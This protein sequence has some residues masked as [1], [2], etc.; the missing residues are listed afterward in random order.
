MSARN[1]T[2]D[3]EIEDRLAG[4]DFTPLIVHPNNEGINILEEEGGKLA[5]SIET[6]LW[7][8]G[9]G[10]LAMVLNDDDYAPLYGG[11]IDEEDQEEDGDYT[12]HL[13]EYDGSALDDLDMYASNVDIERAKEQH[14]VKKRETAVAL[15]VDAALK[16]KL[17]DA[18]SKEYLEKLDA[19]FVGFK[20]VTFKEMIEHLRS[21]YCKLYTNDTNELR[22]R[23]QEEYDATQHVSTYFRRLD[24]F[25]RKLAK[26]HLIIHESQKV[27]QAVKQMYNGG[28]FSKEQL[29]DWESLDREDKSWANL[30]EYFTA[31]YE[32]HLNFKN[33]QAKRDGYE[34][35]A[36]MEEAKRLAKEQAA[37][38]EQR[39]AEVSEAEE[40]TLVKAIKDLGQAAARD[41]EQI[42]AV[43]DANHA[44]ADLIKGLKAQL[45]EQKKATKAL[46]EQ[47]ETIM[48]ILRDS[49]KA[50]EGQETRS[51]MRTKRKRVKTE[52]REPQLCPHCKR[53]VLHDP[54][55]CWELD[56]NKSLR[57]ANWKSVLSK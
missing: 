35:A 9:N 21:T 7:G 15:A 17:Q 8:G 33:S 40:D 29:E 18:V 38:E 48:R 54:D 16:K 55:K 13:D 45:D 19:P 2:V 52:E 12:Y 10:H 3:K 6:K 39:R 51:N 57:P 24:K 53:V 27:T 42:A 32:A 56:K 44:L 41:K 22:S 23:F 25:Q 50:D 47:N 30:Q 36:H 11:P 37:A 1:S 4:Q 43:T 28:F 5:A 26:V 49:G 31:K 20:N 34:S 14:K 46:K